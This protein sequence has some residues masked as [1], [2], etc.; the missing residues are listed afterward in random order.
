MFIGT[1]FLLE[2][3][4]IVETCFMSYIENNMLYSKVYWVT[5]SLVAWN[6]DVTNLFKY[7]EENR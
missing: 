4:I 2:F 6:L 7:V 3:L 1:N 5:K